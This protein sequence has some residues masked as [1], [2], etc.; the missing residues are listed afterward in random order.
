MGRLRRGATGFIGSSGGAWAIEL[1]ATRLPMVGTAKLMAGD[2]GVT[3]TTRGVSGLS[4]SASF[5]G[6]SSS[7]VGGGGV[8]SMI[9]GTISTRGGGDC[10][11]ME[12]GFAPTRPINKKRMQIEFTQASLRLGSRFAG[13]RQNRASSDFN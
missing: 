10:L 4:G 9:V 3:T 11:E 2:S 12:P 5:R 13:G 1:G 8:G 6:C 7:V